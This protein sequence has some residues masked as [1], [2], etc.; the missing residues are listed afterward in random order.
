VVAKDGKLARAQVL[1]KGS[2]GCREHTK[3]GPEFSR[4]PDWKSTFPGG[5][6]RASSL[7]ELQVAGSILQ[8]PDGDAT[9]AAAVQSLLAPDQGHALDLV[10]VGLPR[11]E[12]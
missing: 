12:K 8:E 2:T 5:M 3:A 9:H 6:G 10:Q 11:A 1:H 7:T 4:Q